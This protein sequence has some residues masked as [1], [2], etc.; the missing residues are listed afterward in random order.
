MAAPDPYQVLGVPRTADDDDIKRAYRKLAR[1]LHPDTN[2]DKGAEERFKEVTAAYEILHDPERRRR[3]D[4]F[5]PAC[6]DR[7]RSAASA[8]A[9]PTA[10]A[11]GMD[12]RRPAPGAL[13]CRRPRASVL[14]A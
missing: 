4:A 13:R 3:Y 14:W 1:E 9:P 12:G 6:E 2:P 5:G 8:R 11:Q 7:C 10:R